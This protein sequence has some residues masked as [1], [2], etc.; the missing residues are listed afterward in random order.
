MIKII[1][2]VLLALG[3]TACDSKENGA[4]KT[5]NTNK[6]EAPQADTT[7]PSSLEEL[8]KQVATPASTKTEKKTTPEKLAK[9]IFTLTTLDGKELHVD[10]TDGGISFQG[11]EN[12]VTFLLF[13]GFRCPPCLAEIPALVSLTKEQ[14]KDL[15]IIAMEVQRLPVEDLKSFKKMKGINYTLLSGDEGENAQFISYIGKRAQWSGSIPF[16]V[17]LNPKGEV[18]V[19][20]VGGMGLDEFKELYENLSKEK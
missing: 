9:D 1:M 19:V 3:L 15:D 7:T 6:K 10:E 17:A 20:H 13:F 5:F 14:H 18:K 8:Q 16:L 2:T 4:E 11:H 12:R